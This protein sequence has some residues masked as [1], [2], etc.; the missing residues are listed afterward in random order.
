MV[1]SMVEHPEEHA[2]VIALL[3]GHAAVDEEDRALDESGRL[4]EEAPTLAWR[5]KM[6]FDFLEI[7]G[8][9]GG[10]CGGMSCDEQC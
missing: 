2:H 10:F 4:T 1:Q 3:W 6:D 9:A 7:L 5:I 8:V